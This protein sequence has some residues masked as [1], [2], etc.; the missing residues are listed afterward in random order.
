M[1]VINHRPLSSTQAG[2]GAK[3]MFAPAMASVAKMID[4]RGCHSTHQSPAIL[5]TE[6][7]ALRIINRARHFAVT[8]GG[9]NAWM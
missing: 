3:R 2:I 4:I 1:E 8:K 5:L 9:N 7:S 6:L